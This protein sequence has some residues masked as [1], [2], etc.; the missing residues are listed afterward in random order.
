MIKSIISESNQIYEKEDEVTKNFNN[1]FSNIYK[2]SEHELFDIERSTFAIE[3][4]V[5]KAMNS[6][7]CLDFSRQEVE[8]ALN[9]M[10]PHKSPGPD[11]FGA[12]FF[13]HHWATVG[14]TLVMLSSLFYMFLV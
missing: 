9:Q 8:E 10:G 2:S 11:S 14:D 1:F 4:R 12:G 7:L 5:T 3:P 6:L 13:Q